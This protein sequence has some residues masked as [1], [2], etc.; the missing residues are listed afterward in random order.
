MTD[1]NKLGDFAL[2]T[3]E[4]NN[5]YVLQQHSPDNFRLTESNGATHVQAGGH[6]Y[7]SGDGGKD[8]LDY[9]VTT[10]GSAASGVEMAASAWQGILGNGAG[11][12]GPCTVAGRAGNSF[13]L[14]GVTATACVD[15]ATGALLSGDLKGN[16]YEDTFQVTGVGDVPPIPAPSGA[17]P[18]QPSGMNY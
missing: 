2:R 16:G 13:R 11:F 17:V 7:Y 1:L 6:R 14:E 4:N 5:S 18:H 10:P 12:A 3:A 15:T 8:F 9:G